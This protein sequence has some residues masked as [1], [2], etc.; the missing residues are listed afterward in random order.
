[1]PKDAQ[2]FTLLNGQGKEVQVKNQSGKL[3]VESLPEGLY[4]LRMRLNAKLVNE[5]IQIKH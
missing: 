5:Q 2:S 3:D 4:N 1:L